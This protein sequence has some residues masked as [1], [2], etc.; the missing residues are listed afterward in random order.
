MALYET[1]PPKSYLHA[2]SLA[3]DPHHKGGENVG[4]NQLGL[5][6][7]YLPFSSTLSH[8]LIVLVQPKLGFAVRDQPLKIFI[9]PFLTPMCT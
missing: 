8:N 4:G 2:A 5:E 9:A 1:I 3:C 6:G 7:R